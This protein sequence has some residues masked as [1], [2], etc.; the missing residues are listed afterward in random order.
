MFGTHVVTGDSDGL[1]H[2]FEPG[3]RV[4]LKLDDGTERKLWSDESGDTY[5]V[6]DEDL[7]PIEESA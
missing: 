5:W 4:K 1:D 7:Q 3:T 2:G 6:A